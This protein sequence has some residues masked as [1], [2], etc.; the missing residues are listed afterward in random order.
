VGRELVFNARIAQ[1]NNKFHAGSPQR[2]RV[3]EKP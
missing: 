3:A 2:H 1:P